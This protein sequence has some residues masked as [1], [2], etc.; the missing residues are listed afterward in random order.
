MSQKLSI[1]LPD[2]LRRKLEAH[3]QSPNLSK[4]QIVQAALEY[5]YAG[6]SAGQGSM[7]LAGIMRGPTNLSTNKV[8]H[9]NQREVL[10]FIAPEV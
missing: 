10:P 1:R 5:P 3:A 2:A 7:R 4:R 6:R 8:H 9:R